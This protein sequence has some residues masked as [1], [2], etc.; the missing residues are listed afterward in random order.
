MHAGIEAHHSGAGEST[1]L[2]FVPHLTVCAPWDYSTVTQYRHPYRIAYK[3][4]L[5]EQRL[6]IQPGGYFE[7][8]IRRQ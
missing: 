2:H 3:Y 7:D 5:T 4:I 1:T 8:V 6:R